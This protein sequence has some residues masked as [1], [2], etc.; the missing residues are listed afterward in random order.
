[1]GIATLIQTTIG[2]RLPRHPGALGACLPGTVAPVASPA[3]RAG[4]V[5]R[6]LSWRRGL[7]EMP[8]GAAPALLTFFRKLFPPVVSG[9]VIISIGFSLGHVAV[10]LA[11]GNGEPANFGFA[12]AVMGLI[13]LL[14][15]RFRNV[16]GGI[17]S[18]GAIF[19]SIWL[20]GLGV[21]GIM[22]R[23]DW[24]L[25]AQKPV[26][27]VAAAVSVRRTGLRLGVRNGFRHP[28]HPRR[29]IS[30]SDGGEPWA[31]TPPLARSPAKPTPCAT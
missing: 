13:F 29:L 12:A 28:G 14:N 11:V 8:V 7:I 9:V 1:M 6:H 25:V 30:G 24:H 19:W 3:G 23:L 5:G 20:V 31:T 2:N 27:P 10:R 21:A 4:H 22:G 15:V 16:L 17:L 26:A 18:R